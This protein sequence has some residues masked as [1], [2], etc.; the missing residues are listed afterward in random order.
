[1]VWHDEFEGDRLDSS[2]WVSMVGGGGFGNK[3]LE[4]YTDRPGTST[5]TAAMLAIKAIQEHYRG[6]DGVEREI[7]FGADS[8]AGPVFAGLRQVRSAHQAAVWTGDLAGVLD[9]G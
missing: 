8:Y 4:Y 2:K 1:M 3:E 7:H 9:D 5:S 6:A